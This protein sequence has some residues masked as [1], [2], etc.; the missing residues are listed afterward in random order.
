M[1]R[2]CCIYGVP[3]ANQR[4]VCAGERRS[5][6]TDELCRMRRSE[7]CGACDDDVVAFHIAPIQVL[8]ILQ[9]RSHAGNGKILAL[10][11]E[12]GNAVILSWNEPPIF[13][14]NGLHGELIMLEQQI[15]LRV[16]VSGV[17]RVYVFERR[18]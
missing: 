3:S 14:Q 10:T 6:G 8:A 7:G 2:A 18:Q 4:S 12:R 5:S 16:A 1:H 15:F 17:F 9:I 11:V 13:I